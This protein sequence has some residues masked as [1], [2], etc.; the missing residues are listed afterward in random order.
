MAN[1]YSRIRQARQLQEALTN[2]TTYLN[3]PRQ[4]RVNSRGAQG[5]RINAY[6]TPF[7][8]DLPPTQVVRVRNNSDDYTVLAPRVNTS[9]SGAKVNNTL[10]SNTVVT[11][12]GFSPARVVWFR[13]TTR[14]VSVKISD[15]TRTEYLKYAGERSSC[16]FG[17]AAADDNMHD[18]FGAVQAAILAAPPVQAIN[19]VTLTPEKIRYGQ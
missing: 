1:R 5:A 16:A 4:P 8:Y 6:V 17:R 9:G 3:T 18:A 7:G 10:G 14:S 19:R 15:V 12:G 2:Y 11:R 13:N